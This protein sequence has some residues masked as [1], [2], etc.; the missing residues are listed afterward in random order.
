[1]VLHRGQIASSFHRCSRWCLYK[2]LLVENWRP[3][4]PWSQQRGLGWKLRPSHPWPQQRG[5]GLGCVDGRIVV[6]VLSLISAVISA[7]HFASSS[8]IHAA[9][10]FDNNSISV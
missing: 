9:S 1:M 8:A 3:L 10:S 4:H 7:T 2:L 5:F 6:V